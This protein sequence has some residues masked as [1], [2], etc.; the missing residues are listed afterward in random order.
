M[1]IRDHCVH[2]SIH[3]T[4]SLSVANDHASLPI[5][6]RLFL[7]EAW[8]NDPLRRAK[9]GV[10][11]AI[12]FASK[13]AI[14][15]EQLRQALADGVPVGTVLGDPAYGD[16][17]A[18]RVGVAALGLRYVLGVRSGPSVWPPGHGPLPPPPWSGRGRPATRLRRDAEHRPVTLKGLAMHLPAR[19]W[20]SLTWRAGTQ[21]ALVD[22]AG[23]PGAQARARPRPLRGP[24]LARV[25][26]SWKPVHRSLRLSDR[27][28]LPFPPSTAFHPQADQNTCA[29]H[30]LPAA[31]GRRCGLSGMCRVQS[32]ASAVSLPSGSSP[33]CPDVPAAC[34]NSGEWRMRK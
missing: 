22:R 13:T 5:A 20:R 3:A 8:A 27:R 17:T 4:R 26:S 32:Q 16:E 11:A 9:A 24:Q 12:G 29:T 14:A 25:S 31:R 7:P 19:A 34:G 2:R 18:F 21:G 1:R 33:R 6:Y 30:R 23:L 10:P 15:L 28:A